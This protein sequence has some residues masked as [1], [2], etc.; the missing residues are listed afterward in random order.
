MITFLDGMWLRRPAAAHC[1]ALGTTL[2]R[3]HLAGLDFRLKRANALSVAP[4]YFGGLGGFGFSAAAVAGLPVAA[5]ATPES[6]WLLAGGRSV[7]TEPGLVI[8]N[9]LT[10]VP[11]P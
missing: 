4:L 10:I 9:Q 1:A 3:M 2:A 5:T 8:D 6:R 11:N 7:L